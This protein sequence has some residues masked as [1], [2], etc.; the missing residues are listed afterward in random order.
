MKT[1]NYSQ[2]AYK[3]DKNEYRHKIGEDYVIKEYIDL[4]N[5]SQY[6]ILDLACGTGIYLLNQN[7]YFKNSNVNWHGLDASEYMLKIA[8]DKV[9][10][11]SFLKGLAENLPY[12][13]N[14]FDVIINNYAFMHFEKKSK[15][16]DEVTRVLK[17]NGIF[18]MH[19]IAIHQMKNWWVYRYFPS[20]YFEDLKR[21]WEKDL[22]F[23]EL[24]IR[25]FNVEINI[26]YKMQSVKVAE[27]LVY[28]ENRDI[29]VLT[30]IDEAEYLKGLEK[31]RAEVCSD[32]EAKIVCDFAELF[33]V[34]EKF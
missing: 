9:S 24:S 4:H 18:K 1:T 7:Q 13:S 8:M 25:N 3:Y 31:L 12:E 16:L 11:I 29:S 2:I 14:Y 17:K 19:N 33:C 5:Y 26:E 34:A 6:T 21:F 23:N 20:A 30:L 15:V 28:A 27:L 32:A 22:I 10:N